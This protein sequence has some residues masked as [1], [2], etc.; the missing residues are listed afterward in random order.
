MASADDYAKWLIAN[1]GKK[2]T[3][4]FE[5]VA[6]AYQE[7]KTEETLAPSESVLVKDEVGVGRKMAQSGLKGV[8][9]IADLIFGAPESY[10]RLGQFALSGGDM[11]P[12]KTSTPVRTFL[13]EK[14]VLTPEAEFTSPAGRVLGFTT[15]LAAS[16]GV[17][18]RTAL[19]AGKSAFQ[20]KPLDSYS[21]L[22]RELAMT[23]AAGAAGG[24]TSEF[25]RDIG[26]ESPVAQFLAT[27]GAAAGAQAPFAMRS[28]AGDIARRGFQNITPDQIQRADQLL[29][30]SYAKGSP[31]TAPE[32]LAQV[33]GSNPLIATQRFVENMPQSSAT[34]QQFMVNRPQSNVQFMERELARISPMRTGG[35][36]G[37]QQSAEKAIK[38]A[39]QLRTQASEPFYKQAEKLKVP[40]ADISK[41]TSGAGG[42]A[43][44][45]AINHVIKDPYSG[46]M[47]LKADDAR[48]LIAAKKYLDA[49]Y[50]NFS[51]KVGGGFNETKAGIAYGASRA[52]DD[53]LAKKSPAYEQGRT[54]SSQVATDVVAPLEQGRV[55]QIAQGG[56]GEQGM[57]TQQGVLMPINPQVTK[58]EDIKATVRALRNQNPE[59]VKDWTRQ[60]L[61][62]I[63]NE[64][65]QK[66]QSGENQFGG[67]KF[68]AAIAGNK[69]QRENLKALIVESSGMQAW[70]GFEKML[71]NFEAQGK[72][73]PVGSATA[74][75]EMI[76]EEF[77][78]GGTGVIP[79]A[80]SPQALRDRYEQFRIGKNAEL[81]AKLLTDPDGINKLKQIANTKPDS[82]KQRLLI[83][84]MV[85]GYVGQKPELTE[86]E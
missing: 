51:N 60:S 6:K 47:G 65:T 17:N 33:T 4:E 58:P 16:G 57:K 40:E 29:K 71:D 73:M 43:I 86:G 13:T 46:A 11:P 35:E 24:S 53:Y 67:A 9:G 18:P 78:Q 83:N 25:L 34:M 12:P 62:G 41:L 56:V 39:K 22:G 37:L 48:T 27:G 15:E 68:A 72:R 63:F 14:G 5:T 7:A 23:G 44:A 69:Q 61:E 20:L 31:I 8:A 75:N 19:Q 54:V 49:Q 32:A 26:V 77:K 1:E 38:T 2:G 52:L 55:G 42:D 80:A 50:T 3:P 21:Q 79:K 85:S 82:A 36:E 30:Q 66:L 59:A 84:S 74:F 10:K 28:T 45:D 81:L 70:L 64:A 76:K